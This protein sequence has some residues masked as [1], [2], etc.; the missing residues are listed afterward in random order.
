M[1][2]NF[3]LSISNQIYFRNVNYFIIIELL[4]K[5]KNKQSNFKMTDNK[6]SQ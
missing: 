4:I 5:I 6:Q 1:D 3:L 2:A